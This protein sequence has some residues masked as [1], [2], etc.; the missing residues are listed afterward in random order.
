MNWGARRVGM[1]SPASDRSSVHRDYASLNPLN[2]KQNNK[3]VRWEEP[4]GR[5]EGLEPG[6]GPGCGVHRLSG[7]NPGWWAPAV[8]FGSSASFYAFGL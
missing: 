4:R 6:G 2:I 7:R 5:A 1:V 3:Q 8:A